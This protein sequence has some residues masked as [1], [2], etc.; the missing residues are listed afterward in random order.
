MDNT[1]PVLLPGGML[2]EDATLSRAAGLCFRLK[3]A[4]KP[5]SRK[6]RLCLLGRK[7]FSEA[8]RGA[9]LAARNEKAAR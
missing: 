5:I 4:E 3:A 8:S 1:Y 9:N 2:A 7:W 6:L